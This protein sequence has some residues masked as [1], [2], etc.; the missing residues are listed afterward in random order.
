MYTESEIRAIGMECLSKKLGTVG[1]ERFISDF[2]RNSGDYTLSRR[3]LFDDMTVDEVL[4]SA[5]RYMK[6]NPLDPDTLARL[7]AYKNANGTR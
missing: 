7:E 3:E 1:M 5:D 6:E 4:E 2:I